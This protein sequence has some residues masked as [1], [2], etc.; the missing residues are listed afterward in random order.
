M[1]LY[2][3]E[4]IIINRSDPWGSSRGYQKVG[5][6]KNT[7]FVVSE[8]INVPFGYKRCDS[9]VSIQVPFLGEK[10]ARHGEPWGV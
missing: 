4:P 6:Q 3:D 9:L 5:V 1:N 10:C 8:Y 7:G 2:K